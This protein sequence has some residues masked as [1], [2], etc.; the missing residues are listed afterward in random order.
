MNIRRYTNQ[1]T[2]IFKLIKSDIGRPFTDQ[3]SDLIYPELASDAL[4]VL[5]TLVFIQKQIP[6]KDGRWFLIRIMPYRTLDDRI[7]GLV[8]TFVNITDLKK[9]EVKLHETEQINRL[10]I[11]SSSDIIIELSNDFLITEFNPEAE[12]F[13]GKKCEDVMDRNFIQM[14]VHEN[15]RKKYLKEL[16]EM[17]SSLQN[18]K[19]KMRV[20]DAGRLIK[21]GEWSA[22]VLQNSLENTTGIFLS[23]K[24]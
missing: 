16:M 11:N 2:K 14:F 15:D 24:R 22:S 4:E 1:A 9:T 3:V 5:R 19:L 7:E 12:K 20:I 8:I 21:E 10:L 23:L 18:K 17:L 6:A 13:F